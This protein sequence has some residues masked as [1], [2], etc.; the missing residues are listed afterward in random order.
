MYEYDTNVGGMMFATTIHLHVMV[1]LNKIRRTPEVRSIK[2]V[3]K[4]KV[5]SSAVKNLWLFKVE[6]YFTRD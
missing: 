6:I 1:S 2:N 4:P 3:L 5:H